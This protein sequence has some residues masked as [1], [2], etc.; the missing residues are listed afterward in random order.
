MLFKDL[1]NK[2]LD[3]DYFESEDNVEKDLLRSK[4]KDVRY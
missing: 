1:M 4:L 2:L 3:R